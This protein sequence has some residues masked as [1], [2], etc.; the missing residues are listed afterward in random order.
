MFKYNDNHNTI[1]KKNWKTLKL[2]FS[3][4]IFIKFCIKSTKKVADLVK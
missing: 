1:T 3:L 4:K 2:I